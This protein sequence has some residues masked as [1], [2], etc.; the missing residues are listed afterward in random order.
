MWEK[1]FV[2]ICNQIIQKNALIIC[3]TFLMHADA[4]DKDFSIQ[5]HSSKTSKLPCFRLEKKIKF[6]I[7]FLMVDLFCYN[8]TKFD[9]YSCA[10]QNGTLIAVLP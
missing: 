4:C 8:P 6:T 7:L 10:L 3:W 1:I 2:P 9:G 5:Q